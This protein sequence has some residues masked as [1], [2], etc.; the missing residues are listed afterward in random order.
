MARKPATKRRGGNGGNG[1]DNLSSA[2][3]NGEQLSTAATVAVTVPNEVNI[4]EVRTR[5]EDVFAA[6]GT[7]ALPGTVIPF[8]QRNNAKEAADYVIAEL[9]E[10]LATKRKK[11]A[12]ELA[13]KAGVFGDPASYVEGDTVMVFSDP[14]F[15]INVK[16]GTPGTMIGR[17]EVEAAANKYLGKK[18]SE[19]LDECMKP[20]AATKQV[21]VSMK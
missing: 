15:S 9:L 2:K 16:M 10:K 6:L 1:E 12:A 18:A 11:L 13:E 20:R 5:I 7:E 8:G 14:N 17:E 19:F 21:I 3:S 4:R